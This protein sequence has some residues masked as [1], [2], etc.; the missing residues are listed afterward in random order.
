MHSRLNKLWKAQ[1][2]SARALHPGPHT[3]PDGSI[4]LRRLRAAFRDL[5]AVAACTVVFAVAFLLLAANAAILAPP[6]APPTAPPG[7]Q[8]MVSTRLSTSA[9]GGASPTPEALGPRGE[10]MWSRRDATGAAPADPQP[11]AAASINSPRA[12][13]VAGRDVPQLSEAPPTAASPAESSQGAAAAGRHADEGLILEERSTGGAEAATA[14]SQRGGQQVP[15]I[16]D[17][18]STGAG[19]T[20]E[21]ESAAD[22]EGCS[23]L[24]ARQ[25]LPLRI[26]HSTA[27]VDS[28]L[29]PAA[30]AGAFAEQPPCT[31]SENM[32]GT[33]NSHHP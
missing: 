33:M 23:L 24:K 28:L 16:V 7:P 26:R 15:A 20:P 21:E 32:N 29:L 8:A 14:A 30:T 17:A 12:S 31:I 19:R 6:T 5:R 27:A 4:L 13:A 1:R 2:M 9:A 25:I 18:D 22:E 11:P 3:V 10:L